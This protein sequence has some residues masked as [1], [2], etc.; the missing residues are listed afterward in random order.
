MIIIVKK[1]GPL[2]QAICKDGRPS[3]YGTPKDFGTRRAAEQWIRNHTYKGMSFE[4][5]IK[6]RI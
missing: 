2:R 5:E 4:Y 1:D 6:E 3:K